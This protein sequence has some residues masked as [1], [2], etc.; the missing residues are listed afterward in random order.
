MN[1]KTPY[2]VLTPLWLSNQLTIAIATELGITDAQLDG[3]I[4][5]HLPD[6]LEKEIVPGIRPLTNVYH[7]SK[8]EVFNKLRGRVSDITISQ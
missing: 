8:S 2:D 4:G 5:Y 1:T 3:F 6:F 7:K